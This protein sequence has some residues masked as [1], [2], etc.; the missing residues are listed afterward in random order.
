MFNCSD[1]LPTFL[2]TI[3]EHATGERLAYWSHITTRRRQGQIER[4]KD[5]PQLLP[6]IAN[7]GQ[8]TRIDIVLV[9]PLFLRLFLD[10]I[11]CLVN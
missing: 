8:L 1:V 6:N 7:I 2:S 5:L 10:P 4:S 9:A 11:E 3:H